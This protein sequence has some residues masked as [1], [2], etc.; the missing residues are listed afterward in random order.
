MHCELCD[1]F[2]EIND[3]EFYYCEDC[4]LWTADKNKKDVKRMYTKEY[5][6]ASILHHSVNELKKQW[7]S[8]ID[9]IR[10]YKKNCKALEIGFRDGVSILALQD[11][12]FDTYGFDI[13]DSSKELA[14]SN[15]VHEDKIFISEELYYAN[16]DQKFDVITIREVIEHVSDPDKLLST[17]YSL[18][19]K[20]GVIFIQ[21]P[22]HSFI[23][24]NWK[25]KTHLRTYTVHSFI[26]QVIKYFRM[27]DFY[28]WEGG[29]YLL[30]EK[31]D[32]TNT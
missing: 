12:G 9:L 28:I 15:G 8:N 25:E 2:L 5:Q 6:S 16:I 24:D 17:C 11:A 1:K 31:H 18:L 29:M 21:T 3:S 13:S 4:D 32:N 23:F 26:S 27:K 22:R 14:I 20:N 7:E 19:N 10:K 30:G